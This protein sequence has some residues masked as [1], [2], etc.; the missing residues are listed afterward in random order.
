MIIKYSLTFTC[1]HSQIYIIRYNFSG[2]YI[3]FGQGLATMNHVL[4]KEYTGTLKVLQ[5]K[6]LR[7]QSP[8]ELDQ[9]GQLEV[10]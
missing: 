5:D 1:V 9:V 6:C 4:P 2:L 10:S 3:K 8:T 7:R